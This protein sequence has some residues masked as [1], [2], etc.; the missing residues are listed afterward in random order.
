MSKVSTY[1][2]EHI[3]G[4][5]SLS[6]SVREAMSRDASV[7]KAMPE[8][9]VYPMVTN[10]IRKVMRF[11]WQLAERGHVLPVTARGGGSDQTG[12]AIGSGIVLSLPAHMNQVFEYEPK[13][14]LVR[15]QPGAMMAAL[16]NTLGLQ[17]VTIPAAPQSARYSTVG[18]AVANNASGVLSGK[19]GAMRDWV[20]QL[21]VVL[22]NG[23]VIQ[24]ERISRRELNRK[25]GLQTMEG[26]I[27][28]GVDNL[29]EDNR[30]LI[31][32]L[33]AR[34]EYTN[35]GYC[36]VASVKGKDGSLDLT[37]LFIGSQGTLGIISEMILKTDLLKQQYSVVVASFKDSE[38]ARDA[39]AEIERHDPAFLE[40]YDSELF[41]PAVRQGRRY[42]FL[43][44]TGFDVQAVLLIGFDDSSRRARGRRVKKVRKLLEPTG[45]WIVS[46]EAD[47][48]DALMDMR[49]A[50]VWTGALD[51]KE[52]G[53]PLLL[54]G[55]YVPSEQFSTYAAG[56]KI[57]SEKY[58]I[59]LPVYGRE[60]SSLYYIWSAFNVKKV[61]DRQKLLKFLDDY[62]RLVQKAGGELIGEAGEGRLKARTAAIEFDDKTVQFFADLKAIFDPYN[63]LNPGV[64][65]FIDIKQLTAM[66]QGDYHTPSLPNHIPYV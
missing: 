29:I 59:S 16:N 57:L 46:G 63:M 55:V 52:F 6:P 36:Q 38:L 22:A 61:S 1:L 37:P 54:G 50:L 66:V 3:L 33:A 34:E 51:D 35:S 26:E 31:A 40:Y 15:V 2:Q 20:G 7:L 4:E 9:V 5:V 18:G 27:Y 25:K 39:I 30:E 14:R 17:G 65:Q 53:S 56:L 10:D 32:E 62:T 11:A 19:Y 64:K 28:R 24:T 42:D 13:R 58:K 41:E 47:E 48:A 49:G 44:E 12:A 23:E 8:M 21:E 43:Q 60:L 45:A